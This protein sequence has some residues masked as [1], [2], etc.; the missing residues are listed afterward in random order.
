MK[1]YISEEKVK[2]KL[3][4]YH[5]KKPKIWQYIKRASIKQTTSPNFSLRYN[6]GQNTIVAKSEFGRMDA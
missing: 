5:R 4:L 1:R 2:F 6:Q 3:V